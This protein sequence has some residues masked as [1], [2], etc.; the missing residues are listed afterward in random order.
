MLIIYVDEFL[1]IPIL[2]ILQE[3]QNCKAD[4]VSI[5]KIKI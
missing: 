4:T 1:L 5:L 3:M 2:K